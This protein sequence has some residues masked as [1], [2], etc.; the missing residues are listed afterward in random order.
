MDRLIDHRVFPGVLR[1]LSA[2]SWL[3][4]L[5]WGLTDSFLKIWLL[6]ASALDA[7]KAY[8]GCPILLHP[9]T[10]GAWP[11]FMLTPACCITPEWTSACVSVQRAAL[12]EPDNT[13][14]VFAL[15]LLDAW[16][17]RHSSCKTRYPL[18]VDIVV[19]ALTTE[20]EKGSGPLAWMLQILTSSSGGLGKV[21]LTAVDWAWKRLWFSQRKKGYFMTTAEF[22]MWPHS[23]II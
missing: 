4:S 19:V 14:V 10:A 5:L 9:L 2:L 18:S 16:T 20:L 7:L 1:K 8:S 3:D 23:L 17:D 21:H 22:R 6:N 15:S 12:T 11:A 13:F